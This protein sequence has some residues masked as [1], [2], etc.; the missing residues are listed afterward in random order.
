MKEQLTF[1]TSKCSEMTVSVAVTFISSSISLAEV[2]KKDIFCSSAAKQA[3]S[4]RISLRVRATS[5]YRIVEEEAKK[6]F[7]TVKALFAR[8]PFFAGIPGK[9]KRPSF[10]IRKAVKKTAAVHRQRI[11]CLIL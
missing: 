6:A 4:F 7:C 1:L 5:F 8:I 3:D 2:H 9:I 10:L 11:A